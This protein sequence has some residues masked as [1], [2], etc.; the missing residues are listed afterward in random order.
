[1]SANRWNR[2][3][4]RL[5]AALLIGLIALRLEAAPAATTTTTV[6]ASPQS[7]GEGK[8]TTLTA[9]VSPS[10]ATGTVTFKDG[11]TTLGTAAL[12]SGVATFTTTIG[13]LGP[14][15]MTAAY[16]GTSAYKASTSPAVIVTGNALPTP[17]IA[18]SVVPNPAFAGQPLVW[19]ATVS[20]GNS[21]TGNVCFTESV[22]GRF[23]VRAAPLINGVA[24]TSGDWWI[25][26]VGLATIEA[27][28]GGDAN[29][30][31]SIVSTVQDIRPSPT[32]TRL[33]VSTTS[34]GIG[35][36]VKLTARAQPT[37]G[38]RVNIE[39][40][41]F[42]DGAQVLGSAYMNSSDTVDGAYGVAAVLNVS[43]PVGGIH[44]ITAT[45]PGSKDAKGQISQLPS[46][47]DVT[48]VA[49]SKNVS[50]TVLAADSDTPQIGRPA[51]LTATVSGGNI[52]GAV[53]FR[54]G[55]Q[56]LGTVNTTRVSATSATAS[57]VS[58]FT[59]L[60]TQALSADFQGDAAND[61]SSS[62]LTVSVVQ[63]SPIVGVTATP[64]AMLSGSATT[65]KATVDAFNPTGTVTFFD[66][67]TSIGSSP[68][69][70]GSATLTPTL[71]GTRHHGIKAA[72][73]GDINNLASTSPP[74]SVQVFG[75]ASAAPGPMTW[76]YGYDPQGN[77]SITVD[78]LGR[79]MSVS[80]DR[81]GRAEILYQ[82]TGSG[83]NRVATL[84]HDGQGMLK[85]VADPRSLVTRYTA[86]GLGNPKAVASPDTGNSPATFDAAGNVLT[87]TDARGKTT[88]Y[89]Y[90]AI[91]RLKSASFASGTGI[92]FE[93][94]G[95]ANP[96]LL[97]TGKLTKITDESGS[98]AFTYNAQSRVSTKTQT[99][100]GKVRTLAYAY[101]SSGSSNGKLT[102][103][104]YPSGARVNY[105]YDAQG[106]LTDISINPVNSN[107]AGP[108]T[109]VSIPVLSA[110]RLTAL[111]Q[112]AGWTWGDGKEYQRRY[113]GFSRLQS[114]PLGNPSGTALAAGLLRTVTRDDQGLPTAFVHTNGGQ[115]RSGF[116]Q[117]L[118][119]D[120]KNRLTF[121]TIGSTPYRY[122]YDL[123]GN[124]R[125]RVVGPTSHAATV[126]T[127]SN[128]L[129]SA[130]SPSGTKTF[131]HDS[132]GN[133]LSDGTVTYTYSD[134]GRMK[135]AAVGSNVVSY[136]YD[137]LD[138][139]VSKTGPTSLVS[140]G[141]SY[142]TYDERARLIGEY[143]ANLVPVHESVYLGDVPVAVI[144]QTRSGSGKQATVSTSV[145]F[146]YAD[147]L[148]TPRVIVRNTDHAIVWRWDTAE[149]FGATGP[150]QN[151]NGLGVFAFN[152]RFPGQVY[153][154]ET[155]NFHNG[156]RDYGPGEGRYLQ[157]D[158]VGL[159]GGLNTYVYV[160][161]NP[162]SLIDPQGLAIFRSG[163]S[164]SDIPYA[165]HDWQVAQTSGDYIT[166]W[167]A[168]DPGR[169]GDDFGCR[170][171]SGDGWWGM[172]A[173]DFGGD[174][175]SSPGIDW[176]DVGRE[177]AWTLIC[178]EC[179]V[180]KAVV[181]LVRVVRKA[182]K[183]RGLV[184]ITEHRAA[185]ILNRHRAGTGISGKTEFPAS[186]SDKDI[187][188][189][190][191]DVATDPRSTMG[192][193]KWNSP[194]A[195]GTRDGVT[196]RVDFYPPNHPTY[197]GKVSTAYPINVAPNP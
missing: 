59:A 133:V 167:Q 102:A 182:G 17:S 84:S 137:G 42:K 10:A 186:W 40:I 14:H 147:H 172:P 81:L 62:V 76:R 121:S 65:L 175:P 155:G 38:G 71:T 122:T 116:D 140:T 135:T 35:Q 189:H 125:T 73:S 67:D 145:S 185:H 23:C 54:L 130:Q 56:V 136:L 86:D 103:V 3:G 72:Y 18:L 63:N 94:D 95:G 153:D 139:R 124:R 8:T 26:Q 96:L 45:F 48:T 112:I 104:T 13:S 143:D 126:D 170:P 184:D 110:L 27:N 31:G 127:S 138:Q 141:A 29:N 78:P 9:T 74:T 162:V 166:Q 32:S 190:V 50:S 92:V 168:Y 4:W 61:A 146:V 49:V 83:E 176:G 109:A 28:Y 66:G 128:R 43:F 129:V 179:K 90:D 119:Y 87:R 174:D 53:V 173:P 37:W 21:P 115:P 111:G 193:G 41:V 159:A 55:A 91:N 187:L 15:S 77:P 101:G 16:G 123:A 85:S 60:G 163:S 24:T 70:N 11:N 195:I 161:S 20:G 134:R 150:D 181:P 88:T 44:D 191:S 132:G 36:A 152:Q 6:T 108:N 157:S 98:T 46:T 47:S 106:Q 105:G 80:F 171:S 51:T 197:A 131:A 58:T 68:V 30:N 107:G 82:P 12:T 196:I 5:V 117:V 33:N 97:H 156:H 142:Y 192:V 113:D 180:L 2:F 19:T 57:L 118:G 75:G 149:P 165:G 194:F 39:Q 154:A 7:V 178:P 22:D 89:A 69:A 164:Y 1:M 99:I 169:V 144:K 148:G 52:A 114:Y 64:N 120:E 34:T 183:A 79:E 160:A 151:P 93:Y 177:L 100:G 25:T 158:P 188:H